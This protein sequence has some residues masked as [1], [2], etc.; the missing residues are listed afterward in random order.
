MPWVLVRALP[1]PLFFE[2][3]PNVVDKQCVPACQEMQLVSLP[4]EA[5]TPSQLA[6]AWGGSGSTGFFSSEQG[7]EFQVQSRSSSE[8]PHEADSEALRAESGLDVLTL[9]QAQM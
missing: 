5:R 8:R 2:V 9:Q 4:L 6:G 3:D 7:Y 1:I